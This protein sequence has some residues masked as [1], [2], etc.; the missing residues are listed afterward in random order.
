M[1]P[2]KL[3]LALYPSLLGAID[4]DVRAIAYN[5]IDSRI[6]LYVYL[7]RVPKDNDYEVIDIAVTEVMSA[8]P[9]ILFQKIEIIENHDPVGKLKFYQGWLFVRYE[10]S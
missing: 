4:T 7:D 10:K 8:F 2:D 6:E 3:K 5:Y 9:E 1:N